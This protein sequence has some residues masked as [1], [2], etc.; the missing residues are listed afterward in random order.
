M[1]KKNLLTL[2]VERLEKQD[3]INS[4]VVEL[5]KLTYKTEALLTKKLELLTERVDLIEQTL[6]KLISIFSDKAK[7]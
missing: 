2:I 4:D 5:L 7:K 1:N 6:S 3:E